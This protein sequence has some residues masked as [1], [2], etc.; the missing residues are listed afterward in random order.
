MSTEG[1][2]SPADL[3][4][5]EYSYNP[6]ERRTLSLKKQIPPGGLGTLHRFLPTSSL[7]PLCSMACGSQL[8]SSAFPEAR[9]CR[10]P[11]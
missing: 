4:G 1:W 7:P 9:L 8:A 6:L 10:F 11:L 3:K 2:A 5:H